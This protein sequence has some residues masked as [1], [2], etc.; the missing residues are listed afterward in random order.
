[1]LEVYAVS[2]EK[3]SDGGNISHRELV[4]G[5]FFEKMVGIGWLELK[6]S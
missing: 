5:M 2:R 1:M 6:V 4:G 3:S